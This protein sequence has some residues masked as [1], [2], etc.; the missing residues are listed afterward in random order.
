MLLFVERFDK[1]VDLVF[2]VII[3]RQVFP[4]FADRLNEHSH[5][6]T[7]AVPEMLQKILNQ[8]VV[9]PENIRVRVGF[10]RVGKNFHAHGVPDFIAELTFLTLKFGIRRSAAFFRRDFFR[11]MHRTFFIRADVNFSTFVDV[12]RQNGKFAF[13]LVENLLIG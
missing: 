7:A 8:I 13:R 11:M 4:A 12:E 2:F 1:E 10:D 5:V 9:L 6:G 3:F